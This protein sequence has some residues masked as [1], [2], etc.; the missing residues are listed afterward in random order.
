MTTNTNQ[1]PNLIFAFYWLIDHYLVNLSNELQ[2]ISIVTFTEEAA[3]PSL[4][5]NVWNDGEFL[6]ALTFSLATCAVW[7]TVSAV[8]WYLQQISHNYAI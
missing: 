1:L 6:N 4:S 3:E 7:F 8:L 2:S 5:W